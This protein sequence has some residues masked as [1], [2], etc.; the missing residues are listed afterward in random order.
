MTLDEKQQQAGELLGFK[1]KDSLWW[2]SKV[3]FYHR[4]DEGHEG[5]KNTQRNSLLNA[6]DE[7]I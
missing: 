2:K 7:K 4:Q 1:V 3:Y 6:L 5:Q